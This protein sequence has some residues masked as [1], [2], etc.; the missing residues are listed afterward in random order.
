[1][2]IQ[3]ELSMYQ[4]ELLAHVPESKCLLPQPNSVNESSQ[5]HQQRVANKC[6]L[7]HHLCI[8]SKAAILILLWTAVVG[9]LYYFFLCVAVATTTSIKGINISVYDSL[10]YAILAFVMTFYPL[11]GFIAD[12]CCG[13]LKTV[14]TSL[15]FLLSCIIILEITVT[16]LLPSMQQS[17]SKDYFSRFPGALVL[18]L[19]LLSTIFFFIGLA[20]YQA[21]FIQLGL[22]QL[23]EAR[24]QHLGLSYIMLH[25]LSTLGPYQW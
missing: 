16:I 2:N 10:I 9:T 4:D 25:G 20:G 3:T 7:S 11:S 6:C 18:I 17:H 5:R 19:G 22:D 24:S 8:P 15:C 1:M 23:F 13:R 14:M 12:V 21:N